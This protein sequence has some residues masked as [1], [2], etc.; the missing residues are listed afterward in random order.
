MDGAASRVFAGR[1]GELRLMSEWFQGLAVAVGLDPETAWQAEL[2]LNEAASNIILYGHDDGAPH[3]ITVEIEPLERGVRMTIIDDGRPFNP[4]ESRELPVARTIEDM[5][6]GGLGL[7]LIRS[8][9][10]EIQYHRDPDH[11]VLVL[12]F[13]ATRNPE[14]VGKPPR[15]AAR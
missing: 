6:V 11:N 4:A 1:I 5:P 15:R 2:C 13:A 12:T 9:A 3:P 10:T 7:H 14:V 8:F